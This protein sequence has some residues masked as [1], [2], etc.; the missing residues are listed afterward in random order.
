MARAQSRRCV[1]VICDGHRNDLVRPDLCPEIHG[2]GAQGSRFLGHRAVFPSVTRASSASI[3]TGHPP[4]GHGLHGN[5]MALPSGDGGFEVHNVGKPEFVG[6]LRSALGRTLAVPTLAE[7]LAPAGGSILFSN[8][9]PGAAY[10]HDPDGH[11][12]VYHRAGSYGPGRAEVPD[13][14]IVEGTLEGDLEMTGRFCDE[15]LCERKPPLAVLWLANPDKTMHGTELGSPE[16]RAAIET[17]DRCVALVRGVVEQQADNGEDIL[18]LVGSDHGQETIRRVIPVEQYL[19]E[20]GFKVAPG[21]AELVV[22]PQGSS[23]LIYAADTVSG[24]RIDSM[25]EWL[26]AQ[27]WC[28]AIFAGEALAEVGLRPEGGLRIA[29]SMARDDREN[30]F[31]VPG[32]SDVAVRFDASEETVGHGQHGG[33]GRYETHPFLI[34]VGP[35]FPPGEA[36]EAP[37]SVLDIAPTVLSHLGLGTEA[38]TGIP[39][40]K[41]AGRQARA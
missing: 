18:L 9:S 31:G 14:L 29:V 8:V 13:P 7:R 32:R 10:F 28:G 25:A 39:L 15:V 20:A 41:P 33:L 1:L 35:G 3:A 22:A 6:A 5:E 19:W 37:S 11:G 27:D 24:A 36:Y 23:A 4:A 26:V 17:V 30:R 38:L 16:H 40:Q 2:L 12:H 34:A 21:S